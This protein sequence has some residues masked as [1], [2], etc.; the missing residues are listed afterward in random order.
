ML[1]ETVRLH[2]PFL[3][4]FCRGRCQSMQHSQLRLIMLLEKMPPGTCPPAT[5]KGLGNIFLGCLADLLRTFFCMRK[6]NSKSAPCE[7]HF[8]QGRNLTQHTFHLIQCH[9]NFLTS[10]LFQS[11]NIGDIPST[12]KMRKQDAQTG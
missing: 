4:A 12:L 8:T 9:K 5:G 2:L 7:S 1:S 10:S 11:C 6:P 3:R